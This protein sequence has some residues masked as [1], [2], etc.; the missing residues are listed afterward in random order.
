MYVEFSLYW[1]T[2]YMPDILSMLSLQQENALSFH[3]ILAS[4]GQ[5]SYVLMVYS[6]INWISTN[7]TLPIWVGFSAGDGLRYTSIT[8]KFSI[9]ISNIS[10]V[11]NVNRSGVWIFRVD[12]NSTVS[13]GEYAC[14]IHYHLLTI[15]YNC[16]T[17]FPSKYL[18]QGRPPCLSLS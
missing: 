8:D 7:S 3:C 15:C 2:I 17:V 13:G 9:S 12:G 18:K 1:F 5:T 16:I 6:S 4:D 14:C 10:S 11:S